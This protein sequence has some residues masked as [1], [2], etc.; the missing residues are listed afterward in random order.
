ML[1]S[2]AFVIALAATPPDPAAE[3]AP[4][5]PTIDE[6]MHIPEPLAQAFA[7][8]VTDPK[9]SQHDRLIRLVKFLFDAEGMHLKYVEDANYTV[10]QVYQ[11]RQANCLS[12]SLLTLALARRAGL[13]AY[14]QGI[15]EVLYW[16]QDQTATYHSTHVNVGV[17]LGKRRFTLDV[18]AGQILTDA[19]PKRISD[20]RLFAQFYANKSAEYLAVGDLQ[21]SERFLLEALRLDDAY[22]PIWNNRG[23]LER[24]RGQSD[25]ARA[26]FEHALKLQSDNAGALSN[27]ANLYGRLGAAA[28]AQKLNDR[29]TRMQARNPFYQMQIGTNFE[30]HG[31]LEQALV[32]YKKAIRLRPEEPRFYARLA[33]LHLKQGNAS[34]ALSAIKNAFQHA[35]GTARNAYRAKFEALRERSGTQ[36]RSLDAQE[37]RRQFGQLSLSG[38]W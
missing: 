23:V 7:A 15:S 13:A 20:A 18:A 3:V 31:D 35:K 16:S 34:S 6:V 27:L 22:A 12:F 10:A 21:S 24:R 25:V 9:G 36:E 33:Q 11:Y 2:W 30:A 37:R 8:K 38:R 17:P 5:L 1:T 26:Y 32:H 28:E 14:G 29:L 19:P 4:P